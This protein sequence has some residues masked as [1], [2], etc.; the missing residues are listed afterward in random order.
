MKKYIIALLIVALCLTMCACGESGS[1]TKIKEQLCTGSWKKDYSSGGGDGGIYRFKSNNS[2]HLLEAD[3]LKTVESDG[4]YK[5]D[6]DF[7]QIMISYKS[8][9]REG[10]T[11]TIPFAINAYTHEIIFNVDSNGNSKWYHSS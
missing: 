5:I 9:F 7:N 4:T 6:T 10:K 11:Q 1:K 3:G 8:G 2:V